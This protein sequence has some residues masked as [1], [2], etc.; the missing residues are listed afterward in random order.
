MVFV[1]IKWKALALSVLL[2]GSL[3]AFFSTLNKQ[4]LSTLAQQQKLQLDKDHKAQLAGLMEQSS[5]HAIQLS[6][7]L[8]LMDYP[9][10][11]ANNTDTHLVNIFNQHWEYV[12]ISWGIEALRLFN[13]QGDLINRWGES[14]DDKS[15]AELSSSP[16]IDILCQP[17]CI[18]RT[19][20]PILTR[21][22]DY[23]LQIDVAIADLLLSFTQI[24]G[25]DI[26]ML[27]APGPAN[28]L[29]GRDLLALTNNQSMLPML[30]HTSRRFNFQQLIN[31]T[32]L[33]HWQDRDYGISAIAVTDSQPSL[34]GVPYFLVI[35]DLTDSQAFIDRA[36]DTF[37]KST[38]A[39]ALVS[40]LL[41]IMLVWRPIQQLRMQASLL[42]LL[43]QK[44]F[45]Q[46]RRALTENRRWIILRDE[47]DSLGETEISLANQLQALHGEV[48]ASTQRLH[49]MAMLDGL[50]GLA[51]RYQLVQRI[52]E[53]IAFQQRTNKPF[54]LLY[55]DLDDFKKV[56]DSL[57]HSAGDELLCHVG[58][59]L[60]S[61]V[62]KYDI[63]AR[64]SGDEFA[65]LVPDVD[66]EEDCQSITNNILEAFQK[67][68]CIRNTDITL[69]ASIGI[70]TYPKDGRSSEELLQN[71]DLAMYSAKAEQGHNQFKL[72]DQSMG[73]VV[74]EQLQLESE[75]RRALN[76]QE[77]TLLYQPQYQLSSEKMIGVEALIRWQHPEKGLLPPLFFIEALERTGMIVAVG[78]WVLDQACH[79]LRCWLDQ[80]LPEV[81][82]SVNLSQ[83]QMLDKELQ[84]TVAGALEDNRIPARLLELEITET[85][86]MDDIETNRKLLVWF[87]SQ[88]ISTAI[89]DFGTGYSS[90]SYLKNLPLNTLKIDRSFI[91]DIPNNKA[92]MKITAAVVAIAHNLKLNIVAE[93]IETKQQ[94]QFLHEQGCQTGQGFIY[95]RPVSPD[96]IIGMLQ[97]KADALQGDDIQKVLS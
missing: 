39:A 70:V 71:A 55:L 29:W 51:N 90:L 94:Q 45:E 83:R 34:D 76:N 80:G 30:E 21:E 46:V 42:P 3:G 8:P 14:R 57:G 7:I 24:T 53:A 64:I 35:T 69:G 9:G 84:Q 18:Q 54:S 60:Q 4:Q 32:V 66:C 58:E 13:Q 75:L 88:G 28:T 96:K 17:L 44:K 65:V 10:E 6:D 91:K 52:S 78:A 48:D 68:V 79:D 74:I 36:D 85:M 5:R 59:L 15:L 63:V 87:Q 41:T 73:Q 19:S 89:D 23:Q 62:R 26:G 49:E 50:T 16:H 38:L 12:Q 95:S 27:S 1:S 82:M 93:G 33:L 56:N 77:F 86:I 22:Q 11:A 31:D 61:H 43:P 72:Y 92:D 37:A 97:Q 25:A 20:V 40:C 2:V 81:T 67:T 47:I